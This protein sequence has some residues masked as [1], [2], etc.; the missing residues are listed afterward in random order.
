VEE[1]EASEVD[2]EEGDRR[3]DRLDTV[4]REEDELVRDAATGMTTPDFFNPEREK[5][6]AFLSASST[7]SDGACGTEGL[8]R[9]GTASAQR[10]V[11]ADGARGRFS[12]LGLRLSVE[13]RVGD[14]GGERKPKAAP[15]AEKLRWGDEARSPASAAFPG[16]VGRC[17]SITDDR[18]VQFSGE[19][20]GLSRPP[21][22]IVLVAFWILGRCCSSSSTCD[23][24]GLGVLTRLCR[25]ED[26]EWMR[27]GRS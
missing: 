3:L 2:E 9:G 22:P 17:R 21:E 26:D 25:K 19:D 5:T 4:R 20:G 1:E 7:T 12:V 27:G 13:S 6:G 14:P 24:S 23:R 16:F 15:L 8:G 11:G 18:P 10:P